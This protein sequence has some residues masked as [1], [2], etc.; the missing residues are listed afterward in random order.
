MN[1]ETEWY[2]IIDYKLGYWKED[3]LLGFVEKQDFEGPTELASN[4]AIAWVKRNMHEAIPR[5]T[6][7]GRGGISFEWEVEEVLYRIEFTHDG[8]VLKSLF[9][10]HKMVWGEGYDE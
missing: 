7:D 3:A 4:N 2:E 9:A 1:N 10:G 6:P 5:V 8:S